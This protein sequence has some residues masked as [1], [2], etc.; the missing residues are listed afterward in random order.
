MVLLTHPA[1]HAA[2]ALATDASDM[3]LWAV[4]K[5]HVVV[6]VANYVTMHHFQLLLEGCSFTACVNHNPWIF[7]TSK[8]GHARLAFPTPLPDSHL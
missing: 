8:V 5:H 2:I 6:L 7:A 1:P 3:A 4:L